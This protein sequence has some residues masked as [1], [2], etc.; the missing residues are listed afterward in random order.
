MSS[1][2]F[3]LLLLL[4]C[5]CALSAGCKEQN[6]VTLRG[7]A[8]VEA[9]PKGTIT[10]STPTSVEIANL[11]RNM[12]K[13]EA[14]DVRYPGSQTPLGVRS[15]RVLEVSVPGI[16]K[17]ESGR[18]VRLDGITCS[19]KAVGYMRRVLFD[20]GVTVVVLPSSNS[21]T[22]PVPAEVWMVDKSF[23]D[24]TSYSN[25]NETAITSH[26]CDVK[27]SATSKYNARYAALARE[28][29]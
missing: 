7:S 8:A 15:E 16:L 17:L 14:I 19:A 4:L 1:G 11:Q 5:T 24:A 18:T 29:W 25:I 21:Q 23:Q 26:W 22:S 9:S 3:N 6:N 12:A 10:T 2:N 13:H 27:A 28:A 20:H